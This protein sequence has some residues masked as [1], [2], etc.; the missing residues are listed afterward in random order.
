MNRV[1]IKKKAL[2]LLSKW[3]SES[4]VPIN[5]VQ[6][7]IQDFTI[8]I[9]DCLLQ[10]KNEVLTNLAKF[11]ASDDNKSSE[12]SSMFDVICNPLKNVNV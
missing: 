10:L 2:Y 7:I 11:Q 1:C 6:T 8:F 12:I 4:E 3:Y 5:K 9:N